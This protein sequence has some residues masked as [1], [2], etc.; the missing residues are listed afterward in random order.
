[1]EFI[2]KYNLT[3]IT[4]VNRKY[5]KK[6]RNFDEYSLYIFELTK[7]EIEYYYKLE[8]DLKEYCKYQQERKN[9]NGKTKC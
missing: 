8:E 3:F 7:N 9:I 2:S 5:N 4:S 1:M 6:F